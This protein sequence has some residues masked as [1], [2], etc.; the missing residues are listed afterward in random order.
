MAKLI[1][2]LPHMKPRYYSLTSDQ[3]ST[4]S[5]L[6]ICFTLENFERQFTE[7][8]KMIKQ[9]VA[10]NYLNRIEKDFKLE[11]GFKSAFSISRQILEQGAPLII[12][13]HGTAVTPFISILK[14]I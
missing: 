4:P 11:V 10:S 3:T 7:R 5:K 6:S 12:F 1:E 2:Y 8:F 14:R 9:G 13:C